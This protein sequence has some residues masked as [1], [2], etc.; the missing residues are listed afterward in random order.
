[1]PEPVKDRCTKA[2]EYIFL[3]SKSS[4]YFFD[5]EAAKEEAVGGGTRNRRSVWSVATKPFKGAHFATFPTALIEPCIL[6]GSRVGDV[7]FDPFMGSGTTAA[8]AL[9]LGRRYCGCEVNPEYGPLQQKRITAAK[10]NLT[11]GTRP[12]SATTDIKKAGIIEQFDLI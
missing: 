8:T 2:H 3:M 7:V 11:L 6:A 10:G 5:T 1:M 9:S 4:R 12:V